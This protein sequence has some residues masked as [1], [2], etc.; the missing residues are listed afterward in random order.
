MIF[1]GKKGE[2]CLV[3]PQ[4]SESKDPGSSEKPGEAMLTAATVTAEAR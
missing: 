3:K 4:N 2:K 1:E